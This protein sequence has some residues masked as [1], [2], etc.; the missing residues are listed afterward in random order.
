M[1]KEWEQAAGQLQHAMNIAITIGARPEL[2]RT[3]YDYARM[4]LIKRDRRLDYRRAIDYLQLASTM[5][6][7]LNML[8]HAQ[9]V[10]RLQQAL[11]NFINT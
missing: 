2:A 3:Y 7:E 1:R 6:H 11:P 5:L 8:P 10:Y 4:I 9:A